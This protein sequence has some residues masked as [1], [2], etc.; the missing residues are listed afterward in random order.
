MQFV[1]IWSEMQ[2]FNAKKRSME[3]RNVRASL[4]CGQSVLFSKPNYSLRVYTL[5]YLISNEKQI[6]LLVS[7]NFDWFAFQMKC[8][9]ID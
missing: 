3:F 8:S 6:N 1:R 9:K 4:V 2:G 7:H 5:E